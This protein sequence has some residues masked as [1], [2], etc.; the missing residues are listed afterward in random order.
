MRHGFF[1]LLLVLAAA[2]PLVAACSAKPEEGCTSSTC[3]S[4][5]GAGNSESSSTGNSTSESSAGGGGAGGG[6]ACAPGPATPATGDIPCDVFEVIHRACNPCHTNP[7]IN[8][9][10]FPILTYEDTQEPY[11]IASKRFLAMNQVIRPGGT[12]PMPPSGALSAQDL[13]VLTG[14]LDACAPPTPEGKGCECT[15]P[16]TGMG[17]TALP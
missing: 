14:W 5:T 6:S 2:P 4:S 10:P 16:T 17:C 15:T 8:G 9:A 11:G 1:P 13:K 3:T 12:P 7:P